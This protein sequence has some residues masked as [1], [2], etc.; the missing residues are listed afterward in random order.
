MF[1]LFE[2]KEP[3]KLDVVIDKVLT[4]M[5]TYSPT[6]PEYKRLLKTLDKLTQLKTQTRRQKVSSDQIL[7]T[8]GYLLGILAIVAYE[9]KH[10]MASKALGFIP[11]LR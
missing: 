10:V 6:D 2:E 1:G 5:V 7:M 4:D 8:A 3:S 9:Q 11:K